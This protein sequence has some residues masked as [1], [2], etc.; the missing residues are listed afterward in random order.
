MNRN[1]PRTVRVSIHCVASL[2]LL[3]ALAGNSKALD[4]L[5]RISQYGHDWWEIEQGLPQ[6]TVHAIAQTRDGYLWVGTQEGLARFD[7][8]RFTVFD[9]R[10]T[11]EISHDFIRA[12]LEGRDGSL[13][14]GT[15]GGGLGRFK[16]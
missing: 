6:S 2:L 10:N 16:D 8:L 9:K 15:M 14:I 13:W 4:P 12:L 1:N 3:L 11:P 5:K 7:G